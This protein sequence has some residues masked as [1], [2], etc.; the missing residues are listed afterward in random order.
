MDR[1]TREV[2]LL[3]VSPGASMAGP[4][5]D[6]VEEACDLE[7]K[8]HRVIPGGRLVAVMLGNGRKQ[9]VQ[10]LGVEAVP[11]GGPGLLIATPCAPA[12]E[13]RFATVLRLNATL[14]L[15]AI[16]LRSLAGRD[17]FVLSATIASEGLGLDALRKAI[18]TI[19]E[20]GDR[21]E[22]TLTGA[23]LT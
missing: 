20:R 4:L 6:L 17:F 10:V 7:G 9:R 15:G 3:P 22:E 16:E 14:N 12:D 1:E 8:A 5:C 2:D 18:R 11:T 23:D 21:L 13:A 19:A